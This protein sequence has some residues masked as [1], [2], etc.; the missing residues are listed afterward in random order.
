MLLV[1][2]I[3]NIQLHSKDKKTTSKEAIRTEFTVKSEDIITPLF[4]SG[5]IEPLSVK[6]ISAPIDGVVEEVNFEYGESVQ[7]DR[8]LFKIRSEKLE[9][10]FQESLSNYLKAFDNYQD[11]NRQYEASVNLRKLQ[12]ISDDDFYEKQNAKEE[13]EMAMLQAKNKLMKV[14][15]ALDLDTNLAHYKQLGRDKVMQALM[16]KWDKIVIKAPESGLA[17]SPIIEG[18]ATG[19]DKPVYAGMS[20]KSGQVLVSLG[21]FSGCRLHVL[22]NEMDINKIKTHLNVKI[23]G[24]A[25]NGMTL[26][27]QVSHVSLQAE[28]NT[29]GLP[30]FPVEVT[31]NHLT[32]RDKSSIHVGMSAKVEIDLIQAQVLSIP[33]ESVYEKQGMSFV[34]ILD[35]KNQQIVTRKIQT[36]ETLLNTVI[37]QQGLSVGDVIVYH[38]QP[39]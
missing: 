16:K 9:Q 38:R 13:S 20:V 26:L 33:I 10:D 32:E 21:D 31:V 1:V 17:L 36:G 34:D 37:V 35:K 11:K 6:S 29:G 25:F 28:S 39:E 24:P 19:Q 15:S 27:G 14:L 30:T 2:F 3:V 18:E 4:F 8:V 22:V 7:K 5:V 23:T 12:F